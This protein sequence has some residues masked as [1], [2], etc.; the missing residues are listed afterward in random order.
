MLS[1]L[2]IIPARY[3]S[4][5]LQ[6]KLLR[7]LGDKPII[8]HTYL[9]A[10]ESGAQR[11]IIATDDVRIEKVCLNFGAEV[12]MTEA[13]HSSGTARIAEVI[14]KCRL[15]DEQIIVNLQGDEPTLQ[16]ALIAEVA[17]NLH[18][19]KTAVATLCAPFR[20][21]EEY[22]DKNMVKVV[23]NVNDRALY[24]SRS[25]VPYFRDMKIILQM[26]YRHIGIYAYRA[27]FLHAFLKH[28]ISTLEK[29]ES[30]EQLTMLY[31]GYD[32]HTYTSKIQTGFGVDTKE[33]LE[34][35]R[36]IWRS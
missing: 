6:A 34:K 3:H 8:E 31:Y 9:R 13:S 5:R 23:K 11:I 21:V 24:F 4:S 28:K 12:C 2:V 35:L 29:A 15:K 18:T 14:R 27:S 10:C 30:L 26:C 25:P 7:N 22:K 16:G 36:A 32:I 1:F 20:T 17:Q 33:D 19:Y